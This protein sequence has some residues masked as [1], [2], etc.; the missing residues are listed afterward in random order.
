MI[1]AHSERIVRERSDR[2]L[3]CES[4]MRDTIARLITAIGESCDRSGIVRM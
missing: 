3:D 2:S 1:I 4:L